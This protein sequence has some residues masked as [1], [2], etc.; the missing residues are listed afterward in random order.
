MIGVNLSHGAR[1]MAAHRVIVKRLASIESF[2]GMDV[3]CSDKTGT[4]TQGTVRVRGAYAPDGVEHDD[5]LAFAHLNAVF[6]SGSSTR[7]IRRCATCRGRA[8]AGASST[9]SRGTSR[10]SGSP[11]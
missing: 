9:R 7:S 4:L 11:C 8:T 1:R 10:A 2:G 3:L 6:E 5:V